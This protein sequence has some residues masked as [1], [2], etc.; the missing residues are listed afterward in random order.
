MVVN[1]DGLGATVL[2]RHDW[3]GPVAPGRKPLQSQA[4]LR[5][6]FAYGGGAEPEDS[7][8]VEVVHSRARRRV[9]VDGLQQ[10][11]RTVR[12]G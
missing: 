6:L 11:I 10:I 1:L 3:A 5:H 8:S 4:L 2:L 7:P 9:V 12:V